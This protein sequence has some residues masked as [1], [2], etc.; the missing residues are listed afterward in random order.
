MAPASVRL[1]AA[2]EKLALVSGKEARIRPTQYIVIHKPKPSSFHASSHNESP[3]TLDPSL[4]ALKNPH[5][6]RARGADFI[7]STIGHSHAKIKFVRA[8]DTVIESG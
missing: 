8:S 7:M 3:T 2:T 1:P 5:I 4:Q 6:L